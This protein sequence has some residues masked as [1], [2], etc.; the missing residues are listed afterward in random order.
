MRKNEDSIQIE[1]DV[2]LLP[3]VNNVDVTL[4]TSSNDSIPNIS[5]SDTISVGSNSSALFD[6]TQF[7]TDI[8]STLGRGK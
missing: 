2:P 7:V 3:N 4:D 5:L 1:N 6:S 8:D